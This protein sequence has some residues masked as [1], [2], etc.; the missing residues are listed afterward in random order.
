MGIKNALFYIDAPYR[1]TKQYVKQNIDYNEFYDFCRIISKDNIV[2]ISEYNMPN[3][4]KCIWQK[5]RNVLQKSNR[6]KADKAIEKLFMI[7]RSY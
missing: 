1:D 7:N 6:I 2:I 4:F 5:E 3:D